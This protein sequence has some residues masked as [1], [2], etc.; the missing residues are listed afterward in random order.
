MILFAIMKIFIFFTAIL[1]LFS[2]P[3]LAQC[4]DAGVCS[5]GHRGP[6]A[7]H[8]VS[9][10]YTFG[11]SGTP[12]D[13][14]FHAVDLSG[15]FRIL[16]DSWL[17]VKFPY[18]RQSGPL[19]SL[20]GFG[21]L[22]ILWDQ[23]VLT[24]EA[25]SLRVMAGGKIASGSV[26]GGMLPQSYQNGLGT[27]DLLFGLTFELNQWTFAA[28]YQ[29]SGGR[30][31]N[32]V[33]RLQRGDDLLFRTGYATEVSGV[34]F[35]G[36]V[37]LIQRIQEST[38]LISAPAQQEMFGSVPGSKQT[39]INLLARADYPLSDQTTLRGLIGVPLLQR[40]VNTDGLKRMLTLSAGLA[41]SF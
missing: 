38:I 25:F 32:P 15:S 3:V 37:L 31:K 4:S 27:N 33:D 24:D 28:A 36:E 9:V 2:P 35:G 23:R 18:N 1:L 19:G 16:E 26:T 17:S 6:E 5:I 22:T 11:S 10:H 7:E 8:S 39:Q 34:S 13:L 30:S 41:F 12:D 40:K 29:L 20:S 21:D 14:I